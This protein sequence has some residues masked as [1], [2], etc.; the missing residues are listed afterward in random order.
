MVKEGLE[1]FESMKCKYQAEPGI[2]H[3][4]CLIDL[5]GRASQVND[6]MKLVE[7]CQWNL[8]L[9]FGVHYWEHAELI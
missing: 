8:M 6:A 4:A 2:E 3:C 5:L 1:L 9:L 7:K